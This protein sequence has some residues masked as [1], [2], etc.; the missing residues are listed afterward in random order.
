MSDTDTRKLAILLFDDFEALDV[1]GPVEMFGV[2]EGMVEVG[3]LAM[4]RAPVGCRQGP[5]VVPDYDFDDC[6]ALDMLLVPGG[7]GTRRA[8]DDPALLAQLE[9]LA[10][11]TELVMTV[12]TGSALLARTGLLDGVRATSNKRAF[13]WARSQGPNV[14]WV[15]QA[16][17]VRDGKFVTSAGVSA[18]MDMSL[19]VIAELFGEGAAQLV[20]E[21]TEYER[22]SDSA[23]DPFAALNGL[24]DG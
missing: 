18:G 19:A 24:G 8:V 4:Q 7:L 20:A 6:P 2:L 12:C 17:W 21:A 1:F 9:R 22:H 11:R 13:A 23:W 15:E 5:E 14:R 16:R 3:T 10:R